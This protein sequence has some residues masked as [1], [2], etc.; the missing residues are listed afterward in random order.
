MEILAR[1]GY[2]ARGVVYC[3]VSIFALMAAF[4][5]GGGVRG[6]NGALQ[7][8]LGQPFGQAILVL[9]AVGLAGFAIWRFVQAFLDPDRNGT[10]WRALAT[11]IGY[12]IGAVIYIALAWSALSLAFGWGAAAQSGDKEAQDWTAWLLAQE[13]G[14][15]LAGAIAVA[16]IGSGVA[17]AIESW[18]GNVATHLQADEQG[19][20]WVRLLGRVGYAAS[21]IV[22]VI[23]GVLLLLATIHQNPAEARGLGGALATLQEQPYGSALLAV[24][25]AGLLAFGLFGLVQGIY[26][27]IDAPDVASI[28]GGN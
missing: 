6:S 18:V 11:R 27:R 9:V 12:L 13:F 28:S 8:L 4:G 26:R 10:S 17:F 7:T 20:P 3:I 2:A 5:K 25:A 15:W 19:K 24:V 1:L 22:F 21:G 16:I 23:L 14:R